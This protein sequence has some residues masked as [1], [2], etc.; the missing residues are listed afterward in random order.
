MLDFIFN[1]L[2]FYISLA[3]VMF[4]PGYCLLL[5]VFG[6]N[7]VLDKLEK[8]V[9]SFGLS[10][11][12]IDFLFFAYSG[13]KIP[14]T[15]LTVIIGIAI[16]IGACFVIY[17]KRENCHPEL[18]S[19]SNKKLDS[20]PT[21]PEFE[22]GESETGITRDGLFNFSKNQL[23]LI[24]L[25]IFLIF[26]IKTVFLSQ[27]ISPN[28]TDLG[29]HMY[30]SE[31]MVENHQLPDY[32]G[33][34]DFIIGEQTIF[35]AVGLLSGLSFFSA[36]PPVI[37]YL[38]N[39]L[40]LLAIFI[41]TLRIFREKN[42]AIL[43]LFFVGL[44]YA[45]TA[46][47]A[48]F[49]SGGV[50][51]NIL[52]NFL[53]PLALYFYACASALLR[54][55]SQNCTADDLKNSKV[56]LSLAIFTTFGLFYTHHLTAFIFLFVFAF[57]IVTYL[58]LNFRDAREIL[59]RIKK[60][61]FSFPVLAVFIGGLL[62][63]FF[64]FTP[65]YVNPS[66][67][68]TAVGAPSKAT[69]EGLTFANLK[70]SIG[71]ARLGLG[72][73][74]TLILLFVYRKNRRDFG[75]L[76]ILSWSMIVFLLSTEPRLFFVNLPSDRIGNYL[77]YPF[78]ILGAYGIYYI[79][80]KQKV[81]GQNNLIRS[82]FAVVIAFAL[83]GGLSDSIETLP[84]QNDYTGL[85]QTFASSAYLA[86]K[87][88]LSDNVLKDHNY[89]AG[90]SW[91]KLF[92][93]RGYKFPLSRGY[94][95]RYEDVTKPREMCTLNMISNPASDEAKQCYAD[96]G[97]NFVMV[98]PKFDSRQFRKL[99]NFNQIYFSPEIAIYYRTR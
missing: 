24:L 90:D 68:N 26:F 43:A 19:G 42:V 31:W 91:I 70:S 5:S 98:N 66:A 27:T 39:M 52:G 67:V 63:F 29:H 8:F 71:E 96:T 44:L 20:G 83:I 85:V 11:V 57:L 23:T 40:G 75:Y 12:S 99:D 15:R 22:R 61:V 56:F 93:M 51:G 89:I 58:L 37:L 35:G 82:A 77:S 16:F 34:P 47:Q 30:W 80:E 60:I 97:T 38:V 7:R 92:F 74:G 53:L 65:N 17:K 87:I 41:L 81:F 14:L 3:L 2:S 13:L 78:S 79:F 28:A 76:A 45:V 46:P 62:F 48:K 10:I 84:K 1:Q 36:F 88:D 95:K 50:V 54:E 18:D 9:L 72:I 59:S 32:E 73:F 94:F 25:I 4:L 64:I 55:K 33:M 49:V 86:A 69:R 21:S 6:K